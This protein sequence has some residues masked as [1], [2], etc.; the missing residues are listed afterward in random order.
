MSGFNYW[1][2]EKDGNWYWHLKAGNNKIILANKLGH[3][4]SDI[5][6]CVGDIVFVRNWTM[7]DEEVRE[8]YILR[9]EGKS[10]QF[11]AQIRSRDVGIDVVG[12]T[13]TYTRPHNREKGLRSIVKNARLGIVRRIDDPNA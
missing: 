12:S 11:Y 3:I 6:G 8:R 4:C 5:N 13:E 2:S 7:L 1:Q 9:L 10:G